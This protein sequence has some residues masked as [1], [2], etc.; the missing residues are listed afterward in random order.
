MTHPRPRF[1]V[2][3]EGIINT[4]DIS[5]VRPYTNH[6]PGAEVPETGVQVLF[7]SKA[8]WLQLPGHTIDGFASLLNGAVF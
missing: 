8:T 3:P 5:T 1:I 7:M 4:E 2:L 6:T